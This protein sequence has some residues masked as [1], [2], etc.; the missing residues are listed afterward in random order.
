[1]TFTGQLYAFQAVAEELIA[2]RQQVLLAYEQGL[3]KTPTTIASLE[4]LHEEGYA[5]RCLIVVPASLKYQWI[6]EIRKFCTSKGVVIDG[7]LA[8][9]RMLYR[10]GRKAR[11][12]IVGYETLVNDWKLLASMRWDALVL[13]EATYIKGAKSKRA[14]ACKGLGRQVPVRLALTGQP[15]ENRPE[16]LFSIMEFVDPEVLGPADAFDRTFIRRDSNGR[17]TKGRNLHLL[18]EILSKVMARKKRSDPEVRDELP[19][20]VHQVVPINMDPATQVLYDRIVVDLQNEIAQALA[21]GGGGWNVWEHYGKADGGGSEVRGRIMAC[22]LAARMLCDDP[23]LLGLSAAKF[24]DPDTEGGSEYASRVAAQGMPAGMGTPKF[25]AA[26]ELIDE[27]LGAG[28]K[29]VLF[30]FFKPMLHK[31]HARYPDVSVEFTGDMNA[32]QKDIALQRFR[33]RSNV[34]LLLSSDA[35]GY[36]IDLPES[37]FLIS[38]DLPWSAGKL[39]QRESRIVRLSSEYST[40]HV[41]SLIVQGSIEQYQ[42]DMLREKRGIGAAF[43]DGRYDRRGNYE[44][45]LS[46]LSDFLKAV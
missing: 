36:G 40:V 45:T 37:D 12:I 31:F 7:P 43:V 33:K 35:G 20:V 38:Y 8:H 11:Y 21:T 16:E 25:D 42:A 6:R 34:N 44:I 28:H 13:D 3:G 39:D 29:V 1:M 19:D 46:T 41:I 27:L 26:C 17:M 15:V 23:A 10:H 9:R 24:D 5:D 30:S 14:K 4:R 32:V 2:Q 22:M 18:A